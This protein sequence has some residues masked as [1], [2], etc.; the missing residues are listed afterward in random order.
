MVQSSS[1]RNLQALFVWLIDMALF[2]GLGR[3]GFGY[4][5]VGEPWQGTASWIQA[6]GRGDGATTNAEGSA[7]AGG[8]SGEGREGGA[9]GGRNPKPSTRGGV[10]LQKFDESPLKGEKSQNK[11]TRHFINPGL[12]LGSSIPEDSGEPPKIIKW[13]WLKKPEPKMEPW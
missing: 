9:F 8:F 11:S 6:P 4:G 2:Y 7:G 13:L 10:Q 5:P 1:P 12:A 3:R